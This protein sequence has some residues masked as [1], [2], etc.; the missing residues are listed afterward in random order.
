[1]FAVIYRGYLLPGTEATYKSHWNTIATYF[2]DHRGALGSCLH[3]TEEGMWVA[4]SRWPDK[5]TRDASWPGDDAPASVLPDAI[6]TAIVEL[7]KCLDP[8]YDLP[9]IT[10]QVQDSIGI[11]KA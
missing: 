1:M 4:Y 11:L 3:Q 5:A 6:K 7:K 10:M 2:V 8:D 9:E